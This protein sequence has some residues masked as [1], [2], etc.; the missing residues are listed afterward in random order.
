MPPRRSKIVHLHPGDTIEYG[1][2]A[3]V[4]HDKKGN[5]WVKVGGTTVIRD[6]E[7]AE[8][9]KTRLRSFVHEA[10]EEATSEILD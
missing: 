8:A 3:E 10:L 7:T 2:T 1:R 6:E 5:W 9:A 4:K